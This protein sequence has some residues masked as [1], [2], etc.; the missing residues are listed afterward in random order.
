[1]TLGSLLDDQHWHQFRL[2]RYRQYVNFSLDGE[3]LRFRLNGA[4]EQ[5]DLDKEVPT[6]QSLPLCPPKS[7]ALCTARTAGGPWP[8]GCWAGLLEQASAGSE[9]PEGSSATPQGP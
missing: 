9:G 3:V 5:L 1:M 4:F 6:D 7:P 2:D 8:K